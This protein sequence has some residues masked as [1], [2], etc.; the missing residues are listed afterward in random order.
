[1][2]NLF[3]HLCAG[4]Y[5]SHDEEMRGI[6][7]QREAKVDGRKRKRA[8]ASSQETQKSSSERKSSPI[9]YAEIDSDARSSCGPDSQ[10]VDPSLDKSF[11]ARSSLDQGDIQNVVSPGSLSQN[12]ADAEN[13]VSPL[14][15]GFDTNPAATKQCAPSKEQT[16]NQSDTQDTAATGSTDLTLSTANFNSQVKVG[17][18]PSLEHDRHQDQR[19]QQRKGAY[20]ALRHGGH[21]AW[22]ADFA[23]ASLGDHGTDE[24]EL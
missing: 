11:T 8:L 14:W 17:L 20:K 18:D 2:A 24:V 22:A 10:A 7:A 16:G 23:L 21:Q 6:F 19:I 9:S 1:M 13:R 12:P 4:H 5:F 15:K 3:G